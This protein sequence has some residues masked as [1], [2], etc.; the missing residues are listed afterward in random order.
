VYVHAKALFGVSR[1]KP[2]PLVEKP[3]NF[4]RFSSFCLMYPLH[5]ILA[6]R[7]VGFS[8]EVVVD[9]GVGDQLSAV[10]C[11]PVS[12]SPIAGTEPP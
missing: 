8:T 7:E 9:F 11:R 12:N 4:K 3:S 10:N 5:V 6:R 1:K 2:K